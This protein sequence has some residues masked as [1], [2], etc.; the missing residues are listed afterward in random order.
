MIS[1]AWDSARWYFRG[2][3]E[4]IFRGPARE[5]RSRERNLE[6]NI[7]LEQIP[8]HISS[9]I[10]DKYMTTKKTSL[11]RAIKSCHN[12]RYWMLEL[13]TVQLPIKPPDQPRNQ[14]SSIILDINM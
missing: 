5:T 8:E 12:E 1:I 7:A 4:D 10:L 13:E 3:R 2:D 6:P 9:L 14:S 11:K